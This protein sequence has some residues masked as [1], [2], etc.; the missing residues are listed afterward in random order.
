LIL[1]V[2][3]TK[4]ENPSSESSSKNDWGIITSIG[5]TF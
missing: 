4:Q 1:G 3:R 5:Y 2:F